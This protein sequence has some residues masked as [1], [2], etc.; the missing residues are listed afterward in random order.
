MTDAA[1]ATPVQSRARRILQAVA[2]RLVVWGGLTVVVLLY[3]LDVRSFIQPLSVRSPAAPHGNGELPGTADWPHLRGPRYDAISPETALADSWP[4]DGPPVLWSREIGEGYSGIIV[5]GDRAYTQRQTAADQSLLCLDAHT[6]E[7]VWE[8]RYG[9]PYEPRGQ[10]PGPRATPT[11]SDGHIYFAAPDGLVGCLRVSDGRPLWSLNV[12]QQFQGSGT[13]FG[14]ACT[15]L[16]EEGKVVL[17]VGGPK[18]AVVA[19]AAAD[20]STVWTSGSQPASYC[21]ALPLT[22]RGRRLVI[23]FLQNVLAALDLKTGRLLWEK[24]Y[25]H[26]YDEHSAA[27]LYQEPHLMVMLPFKAGSDLYRLESLE[28]RPAKGEVLSVKRLRHSAAMSNDVA[29]SVLLDGFVYGFDLH[30]AQSSRYRASR[31]QFTCMEFLSGKARWTTDRVGHATVLAAEGKLYL[32]NETGELILARANPECYEE[33][34]RFAVFSDKRCWTAPALDHGRLYLRSPSRAVCV[35][36]GRPEGLAEAEQQRARMVPEI[37]QTRVIDA[38]W[39]L[40]RE[41][42]HLYDAPQPGELARWY[43]FS[44]LG[45]LMPAMCLAAVAAG[46][47]RMLSRRAPAA[48]NAR[49]S[50]WCVGW[51]VFWAVALVLGVAATPL[52]NRF[53]TGFVFTWPVSLFAAHQIALVAILYSRQQPQQRIATW[54]SLAAVVALLGLCLAYYDLCRRL[55]L[56]IAWVFLMGFL[57]SWPL[58]VLAARRLLGGRRPLAV[59]LWTLLAFSLYFGAASGFLLWRAASLGR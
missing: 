15:P 23:A 44:L 14:Y 35:Y 3:C 12:N 7:T 18:A 36:V 48:A 45:V 38:K 26:G 51:T 58:A 28:E 8:H 50:S 4:P 57:P 1:L 34:G 37:P 10:Y 5:V 54:M 30:A 32:L 27:P 16:V 2:L 13:D 42:Q 55:A 47:T 25:S 39:L 9:W 17:P 31:G 43:A 20:G 52:G 19:L 59:L 53:A 33:L 29:S 49:C 24:N 40:G 21:S 22:Y 6:G 56:A 46:L 11:Y 41:R